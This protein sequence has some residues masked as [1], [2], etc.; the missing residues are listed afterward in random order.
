LYFKKVENKKGDKIDYEIEGYQ[1]NISIFVDILV[2]IIFLLKFTFTLE[3]NFNDVDG[4]IDDNYL[5]HNMEE[6]VELVHFS[7]YY[8]QAY[9]LYTLILILNMYNLLSALRIFRII[10]WILL[11]VGRTISTLLLFMTMLLPM[12]IGFSFL[13]TCLIGPYFI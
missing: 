10:H 11:I 4:L 12:Q 5:G 8:V 1:K 13:S 9:Q 2:I 6:Y 7:D 3:T